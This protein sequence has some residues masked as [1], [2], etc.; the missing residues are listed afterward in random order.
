MDYM[1]RKPAM[2][3]IARL[4]REQRERIKEAI[5]SIP[6]GD[7]LPLKGY[8]GWFRLR[9][10]G[11]RLIYKIMDECIYIDTIGPRGDVYK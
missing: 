4:P 2:K 8:E 5:E 3:F 10:G 9:I 6:A 1:L 7:I 11:F